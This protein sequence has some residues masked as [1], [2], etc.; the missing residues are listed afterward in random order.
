MLRAIPWWCLL[1]LLV[2]GLPR[3]AAAK[4]PLVEKYL[5]GE[6]LSTGEKALQ[7]HLRK[8]PRDHEA[9]FGLGTL[10]FIQAIEQLG[11][12][13][14]EYGAIG[15]RTRLGQRLPILRIA[16]PE[17]PQ[18][19]Q[20]AYKDVRRI[21][22]RFIDDLALAERTLVEVKDHDVKLPLHMGMIRLDLNGD[23]KRDEDETLW[24]IYAQLNTGAN[25]PDEFTAQQADAFVITFDYADA[26]WLRGYCHLLSAMGESMLMYDE[27]DAFNAI[28]P[29]A[30]ARPPVEAVPAETF[31][32]NQT[33]SDIADAIAFI[34]LMR[35]PVVEPKR[36][37][38]ALEHLR[39]VIR[40][41]K[42][43]WN[44]IEAETDD[45]NEWVPN[46]KQK[47][48]IP[49]VQITREMIAGWRMFLS[50]A[51]QIV[52]GK[53]LIPHWRLRAEHGINLKRVFT[54]PREFDAVLWLHGAGAMPYLE[55]GE[56]TNRAT[57]NRFN[58]VFGGQFI[59]FAFWFN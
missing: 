27:E 19:K 28:A 32:D 21:V 34:H 33:I 10:Q 58:T 35:F 49:G 41:S 48:V 44:A 38:V 55:K 6:R 31:D 17:N 45:D 56:C 12:S 23:D 29:H 15:S 51:E 39:E 24:K 54:E 57:W 59:G 20:V 46:P 9:R 37:E 16:V 5:L 4:V 7:E 13:L 40:L 8:Q 2:C 30:F 11:Q 26:I 36:G 43:N 1:V 14:H 52:A 25:L 42:L 22:Q 53:K 3:S 47:G 50:E 18:P